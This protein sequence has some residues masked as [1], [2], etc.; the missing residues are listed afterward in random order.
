MAIRLSKAFAS[1]P[2]IWAG[3]QLD[4]DMARAMQNADRIDVQRITSAAA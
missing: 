4:Y 2:E 1:K 3:L